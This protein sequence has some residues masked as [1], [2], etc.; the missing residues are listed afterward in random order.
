MK[1]Y[2]YRVDAADLLG[3]VLSIPRSERA[4]AFLQLAQDL[5]TRSK[6]SSEYAKQLI[7][8]AEKF[9]EQKRI[10]GSMGGKQKASRGLAPLK[11]SPSTPLANNNSSNNN[12]NNKEKT[13]SQDFVTFW[14][15]YP[16]KIGKDDAW[17]AWQ[18]AKP[19][20]ADVMNSLHWQKKSDQWQKDNGQFIPN[21]ATYI[22]QGRWKDEKPVVQERLIY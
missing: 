15:E 13:Y 11:H 1:P 14:G 4:D 20:I 16:K 12:N 10:A 8:E 19:P 22:N 2:F 17:K 7:S 5:V 9:V 6:A 3:Y 18:K 21:P